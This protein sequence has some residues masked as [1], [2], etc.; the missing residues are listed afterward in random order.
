MKR[1]HALLAA[2]FATL[3]AGAALAMPGAWQLAQADQPLRRGP[4]MVQQ[5][6]AR[7]P[8]MNQGMNRGGAGQGMMGQG[9]MGQG[10]NRG[11][12]GPG[13]MMA[14]RIAQIDADGDG[15]I[16]GAELMD[17]RETVFA[18]MD[19]DGDE[20]LTRAEYMAVQLGRGAD[21]DRRGPRYEQMQAA[22]AAE[23]DAMDQDGDG[24]ISHDQ[25]IDAAAAA[26]IAADADGDGALSG[27][28]FPMMHAGR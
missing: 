7:G 19:A 14:E 12:S 21:A 23:F 28:E 17:W 15:R 24:R 18:A 22:K 3:A 5:P 27:A 16:S 26:F 1:K 2:A 11:G 6:Q 25:F 13:P 9:M 8:M 20:T 10:M 4:Q